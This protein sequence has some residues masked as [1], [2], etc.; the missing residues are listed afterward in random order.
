MES[1]RDVLA[2]ET[3]GLL[4]PDV[5]PVQSQLELIVDGL[6]EYKKI[7]GQLRQIEELQSTLDRPLLERGQWKSMELFLPS[8]TYYPFKAI[9]PHAPRIAALEVRQGSQATE[10]ADISRRVRSIMADYN[11]YVSWISL[12]R[13]FGSI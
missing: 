4:S 12:C 6:E 10:I 9:L 7:A 5:L 13:H 1:L 11:S 3:A 2:N 8:L